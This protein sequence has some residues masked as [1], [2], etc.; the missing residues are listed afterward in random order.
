MATTASQNGHGHERRFSYGL[1]DDPDLSDN[2]G[3]FS[4]EKQVKHPRDKEAETLPDPELD[5]FDLVEKRY[6]LRQGLIEPS[7]VNKTAAQGKSPILNI[8]ALNP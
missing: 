4:C 7:Y 1:V 8:N 5:M 3:T 2:P 6:E